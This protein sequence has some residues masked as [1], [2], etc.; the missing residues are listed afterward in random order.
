MTEDQQK[1]VR[2]S[3]AAIA[4]NAA[5]KVAA[6]TAEPS[7]PGPMKR[8]QPEQIAG[9]TLLPDRTQEFGASV[10]VNI[11]CWR[12][13]ALGVAGRHHVHRSPKARA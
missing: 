7:L 13:T 9:A 8:V 1:L 6:V 4:P 11:H 2:S 3:F 10:S 12:S 5:A